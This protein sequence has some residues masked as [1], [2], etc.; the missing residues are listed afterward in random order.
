MEKLSIRR[1]VLRFTGMIFDLM[2]E[3]KFVILYDIKIIQSICNKGAFKSNFSR[4]STWC[5]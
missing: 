4:S 1:C 2:V 5:L 3:N